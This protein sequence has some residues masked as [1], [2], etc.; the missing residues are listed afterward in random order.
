MISLEK[1][2]TDDQNDMAI[3]WIDE[4]LYANDMYNP[5]LEKLSDLV[6]EFEERTD[7]LH[8]KFHI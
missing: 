5:E 6:W 8:R 2:E 4:Y 7:I 1:L 3:D